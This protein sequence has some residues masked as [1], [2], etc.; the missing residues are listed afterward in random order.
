MVHAMA[1]PA[2]WVAIFSRGRGMHSGKHNR[3]WVR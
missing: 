1:I 2:G 3:V